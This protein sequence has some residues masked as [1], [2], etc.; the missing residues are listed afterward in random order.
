MDP[1]ELFPVFLRPKF[2]E[3]ACFISTSKPYFDQLFL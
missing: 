2:A 3:E 1:P